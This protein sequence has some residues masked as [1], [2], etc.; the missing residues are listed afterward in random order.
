[1]RLFGFGPV[2]ADGYGIGYIIEESG[3]S[4]YVSI[5]SIRCIVD[6]DECA[7]SVA[8]SKHLQTR[9]FKLTYLDQQK[10]MVGV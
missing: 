3:I 9:R 8:S 2:A 10:K 4:V 7:N 5:F 1:L 6:T